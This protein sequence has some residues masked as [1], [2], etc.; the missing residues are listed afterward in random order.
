MNGLAAAIKHQ[1]QACYHLGDLAGTPAMQIVTTLR[2]RY[3]KDGSLAG[4]PQLVEQTGISPANRAYAKQ[5]EDVARRAV[6][7]CAPV[8]LPAELYEGG[9]D[10][11]NFRF[12]PGQMQ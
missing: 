4:N 11:L 10:D 5:I 3:K 9:W 8:H 1:V 6:L 2:I 7:R 12:T